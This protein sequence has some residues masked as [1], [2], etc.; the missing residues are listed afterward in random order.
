MQV[1]VFDPPLSA[2]NADVPVCQKYISLVEFLDLRGYRKTIEE[3]IQ[4]VDGVD[5]SLYLRK[6]A[7]LCASRL[8]HHIK[9][10]E[11]ATLLDLLN[12]ARLSGW[13]ADLWTAIQKARDEAIHLR[14]NRPHDQDRLTSIAELA[15]CE[16]ADDKANIA[17]RNA[18]VTV[19]CC[20]YTG[21]AIWTHK[22][23]EVQEIY[24]RQVVREWQTRQALEGH[25]ETDLPGVWNGTIITVRTGFLFRTTP[26]ELDRPVDVKV[27]QTANGWRFTVPSM[28][29][30]GECFPL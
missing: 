21:S 23:A 24:L 6:F 26:M 15:V 13:P 8:Q 9:S 25:S 30:K 7:V 19:L 17:A 27:R 2:L 14:Q 5:A 18:A 12:M 16:A 4:Y 1:P 11:V 20:N 22:E 28:R 29:M 10:P 3:A